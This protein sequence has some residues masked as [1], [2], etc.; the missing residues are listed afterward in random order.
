MLN[1]ADVVRGDVEECAQVE[2]QPI[3]PVHLVGLGGDLHDHVAHAGIH[4][5]PHHP[6]EVQGLRGRQFGLPVVLPVQAVVDGRKEGRPSARKL[7]E[8]TLE[9]VG[10]GRL[11]L[12][13]GDADQGEVIL[14]VSIVGRSQEAHGLA[15]VGNDDARGLAPFGQVRL[16]HIGS[17]P[18]LVAS[19]QVFGLEIPLAE[20]EAALFHLAGVVGQRLELGRLAV[21]VRSIQGPVPAL[22]HLAEQVVPAQQI[23]CGSHRQSHAVSPFT[24]WESGRLC[25]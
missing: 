10:G 13:S 14:R 3:D 11:P 17:H 24:H 16:G 12:G 23:Q 5:L 21:L 1:G 7:V 8:H 4:G 22:N 20:E 18:G 6:E 25:R 19:V 15:Y 9:E 2:G